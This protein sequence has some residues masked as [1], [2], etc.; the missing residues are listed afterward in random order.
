VSH[1]GTFESAP[2]RG[3]PK[4]SDQDTFPRPPPSNTTLVG[5]PVMSCKRGFG[6]SDLCLSA[7]V[8]MVNSL[9]YS[10]SLFLSTNVFSFIKVFVFNL[11]YSKYCVCCR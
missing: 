11:L 10:G 5:Q 7:T 6:G 2:V 1:P 3:V 8:S 4:S 9:D